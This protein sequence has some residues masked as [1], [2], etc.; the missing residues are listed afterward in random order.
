MRIIGGYSFPEGGIEAVTWKPVIT[1][2]FYADAL[3]GARLHPFAAVIGGL[4][5]AAVLQLAADRYYAVPPDPPPPTATELHQRA[6]KLSRQAALC[7]MR[8]MVYEAWAR[9]LDVMEQ[10]HNEGRI[11]EL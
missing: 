8:A 2:T 10:K 5:L 11:A 7:S 4:G 9:K 1:R 6:K 3:C